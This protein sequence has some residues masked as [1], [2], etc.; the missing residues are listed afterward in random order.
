MAYPELCGRL[1]DDQQY[2]T[3]KGHS[4]HR[5]CPFMDERGILRVNGRL[6]AS[7]YPVEVRQPVI[8]PSSDR[9]VK[10]FVESVHQK[11]HHMHH[12]TVVNEIRRHYYCPGLKRLVKKVATECLHCRVRRPEPVPPQEGPLPAARA[13]I[14]YRAF[15]YCGVDYFGP[16][17]V[18]IGRRREKRWIALFTCLTTRAVH[19]EIAHSLSMESCLMCIRLLCARRDVV[20]VEIRSDRGTNFIATDKELRRFAERFP[21]TKWIFNP[22]GAPHMGGAWERMVRTVKRCFLEVVGDRPLT[23]EILRCALVE[24]EW[25]VNQ[26]PLT[27]VAVGSDEEPALTPN[28]FLHGARQGRNRDEAVLVT[29]EGGSLRRTWRTAQQIADHFWARFSKEVIPTLNLPTKWFRRAEPLAV[30]DA[31]MLPDESRRGCWTRGR[32]VETFKGGRDDQVRQV[33]V[34]TATGYV[35]RPSVKVARI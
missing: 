5:V 15:T 11:Y 8:L 35:M 19:V 7:L 17:E 1:K 6:P 12:S 34:Q 3:A 22:P 4:L 28:D 2:V 20:P 16:L 29:A 31:V 13:A 10:L 32:V 30:G 25:V 14:G 24:A 26:H 33:K 18:V 27:Y 23:D 9:I 21:T